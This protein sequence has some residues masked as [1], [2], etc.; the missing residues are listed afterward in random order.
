MRLLRPLQPFVINLH[1]VGDAP[2]PY[3]PGE[4]PYWLSRD[5]LGR[6]LD[7]IKAGSGQTTIALTV[8]DGNR[9]D[10]EII[11]PEL[12]KRGMTATFFVLAGRLDQPGHLR[13][14]EVRDLGQDG[15]EI[16]SHGLHH[17][18]WVSC[19][20]ATL[21]REVGE[22]KQIIEA[23][24]GRSVTAASAPFGRYDRRVLIALARADYR[25]VFSSDGGPRLTAGWPT[26]RQTLRTGVDIAALAR[27]IDMQ[28][29]SYR[30]RTEMR[31]L[32]KSS[33]PLSAMRFFHDGGR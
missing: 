21:A 26:P 30:A 11:A 2:R 12:R 29:L 9:S 31:A 24:I 4:K 17:V 5:E 25:R 20:D 32:V 16:G 18:D 6:V 15:F 28:S 7:V 10:Y 19:D 14:S 13:R 8:D 22:S 23:V 3:E 27:Q 33:L 1:G